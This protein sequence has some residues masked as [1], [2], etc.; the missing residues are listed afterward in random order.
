MTSPGYN[1][2]DRTFDN[3][4]NDPL[5][6]AKRSGGRRDLARLL[7]QQPQPFTGYEGEPYDP[8]R[9][10]QARDDSS[11]RERLGQTMSRIESALRQ[12]GLTEAERKELR[13]MAKSTFRGYLN[14]DDPISKFMG[15]LLHSAV[16]KPAQLVQLGILDVFDA[17]DKEIGLSDYG[18][19]LTGDYQ[20]LAEKFPDLL[21]E[22]GQPSFSTILSAAGWEPVGDSG[23]D[24]IGSG[25]M[26]KLARF[27]TT[28]AGEVATDPWTYLTLAGGAV[29]S[30]TRRAELLGAVKQAKTIAVEQVLVGEGLDDAALA[31]LRRDLGGEIVDHASTRA[32]ERKITELLPAAT[33]EAAEEL[34]EKS[35]HPLLRLIKEGEA[36]VD[37]L[38]AD[39]ASELATPTVRRSIVERAALQAED[40]FLERTVVPSA[41][42]AFHKIDP[43]FAELRKVTQPGA[44]GMFGTGLFP[45][46]VIGSYTTGGVRIGG[47]FG[48]PSVTIPGSVGINRRMQDWVA[49]RLFKQT[50]DPLDS[51]TGGAFAGLAQ[52]IVNITQSSTA[53][54]GAR[55]ASR[56]FRRISSGAVQNN[57][58]R[59]YGVGALRLQEFVAMPY[60]AQA[61]DLARRAA[62]THDLKQEASKAGG[63][64]EEVMKG[65]FRLI[66]EGGADLDSLTLAELRVA[67]KEFPE[68][69]ATEEVFAQAVQTARMYQTSFR[70]AYE[71]MKVIRP[72]LGDLGPSYVPTM[73]STAGSRLVARLADEGIDVI[74]DPDDPGAMILGLMSSAHQARTKFAEVGSSRHFQEREMLRGVVN[75]VPS[76]VDDVFLISAE[77]LGLGASL[78]QVRYG[79][80]GAANDAVM[81]ALRRVDELHPELGLRKIIDQ[82]GFTMF[83]DDIVKTAM[84]YLASMEEALLIHSAADFAE[85]YGMIASREMGS[86]FEEIIHQSLAEA[87]TWGLRPI[88]GEEPYHKLARL[89]IASER[90]SAKAEQ[91]AIVTIGNEVIS[92]SGFVATHPRWQ[93]LTREINQSVRLMEKHAK[94]HARQ[95]D[96]L[97]KDLIRQGYSPG[98]ADA[99]S[100]GAVADVLDQSRQLVDMADEVVTDIQQM[101]SVSLAD[102]RQKGIDYSITRKQIDQVREATRHARNKIR[103]RAEAVLEPFRQTKPLQSTVMTTDDLVNLEA[104]LRS[105]G[106]RQVTDRAAALRAQADTL[107]AE[108][109]L[110]G[111][112]LFDL[113]GNPNTAGREIN[114]LRHEANV[115]ERAHDP[116]YAMAHGAYEAA[117]AEATTHYAKKAS[118]QVLADIEAANLLDVVDDEIRWPNL[119]LGGRE[120]A[121]SEIAADLERLLGE[122]VDFDSEFFSHPAILEMVSRT[123][124]D[125]GISP[126]SQSVIHWRDAAQW[127]EARLRTRYFQGADWNDADWAKAARPAANPFAAIRRGEFDA[128]GRWIK[129]TD[130]TVW[131]HVTEQLHDMGLASRFEVRPHFNAASGE[132]TLRLVERDYLERKAADIPSLTELVRARRADEALDGPLADPDV[133]DVVDSKIA[134]ED[135]KAVYEG[136]FRA[137]TNNTAKAAREVAEFGEATERIGK[138]LDV[139]LHGTTPTARRTL[140]AALYDIDPNTGKWSLN[141]DGQLLRRKMT[142]EDFYRLHNNAEYLA[143]LGEMNARTPSVVRTMVKNAKTTQDFAAEMF[144]P[145]RVADRIARTKEELTKQL[146]DQQET[147]QLLDEF[148]GHLHTLRSFAPNEGTERARLAVGRTLLGSS[149]GGRPFVEGREAALSLVDRLARRKVMV[150][151]TDSLGR[152]RSVA[153]KVFTEQEANAAR[154]ALRGVVK[155]FTPQVGTGGRAIDFGTV[156]LGSGPLGGKVAIAPPGKDPRAL[157]DW[158][159]SYIDVSRNMFT[160]AGLKE[161]KEGTNQAVR[162]WR[163]AVT[164]SKVF[165]FN[166]R[167]LTGAM[168]Q[169]ML[170]GIAP[171]DPLYI[172]MFNLSTKYRVAMRRFGDDRLAAIATLPKKWQPLMRAATEQPGVLDGFAVNMLDHTLYGMAPALSRK[173]LKQMIN[174][175]S[176]GF[177][178]YRA[179]GKVMETVEDTVRLTLF[180]KHFSEEVPHS[181][182]NAAA[183]VRALHFDYSDLTSFERQIQKFSPFWVWWSRNL[184]LQLRVMVERPEMIMRYVK[185]QRSIQDNYGGDADPDYDLFG[186]SDYWGPYAAPTSFFLEKDSPYWARMFIDLDMPANDLLDFPLFGGGSNLNSWTTWL[187]NSL[188]PQVTVANEF[189]SPEDPFGAVAPFPLNKAMQIGHTLPL[190]LG[191]LADFITGYQGTYEATGQVKA[192]PKRVAIFEQ[193]FPWWRNIIEPWMIPEDPRRAQ[194]IGINPGD[195]GLD[196]RARGFLFEQAKGLGVRLQTP[197]DQA[198]ASYRTEQE[199]K[200][201]LDQIAQRNQYMSSDELRQQTRSRRT[202]LDEILRRRR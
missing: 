39:M 190:G 146:I 118:R 53:G 127:D 67:S 147:G 120:V 97:R 178:A 71:R 46:K 108:A 19:V 8:N 56:P 76:D 35:S 16:V 47:M 181:A 184:N 111:R 45:R 96:I 101:L 81:T 128:A 34:A 116:D 130:P 83:E 7:N 142:D 29:G 136:A 110:N 175:L 24:G 107:D 43:D 30:G 191:D 134:L 42:R 52:R 129:D 177:F 125:A 68:L 131:A 179:G 199:I 70:D 165:T 168:M 161:L 59:E 105:R 144:N 60:L 154:E 13:A 162:F 74:F 23:V 187:A 140:R 113:D 54:R 3:D 109:R 6:I 158:F 143:V 1:L 93:T 86:G 91:E 157:V 58:L 27:L 98:V 124:D 78:S 103:K 72:D 57:M 198:S 22:R 26:A 31:V 12:P 44:R 73:L 82:E 20:R 155:P 156:G 170:G 63:D 119:T 174:P 100:R 18:S 115:L 55:L 50:L 49:E 186:V 196:D 176:D 126:I 160:A 92:T 14:L 61:E 106:G 5:N 182:A 80:I 122:V 41:L 10:T 28:F 132:T 102:A 164:T 202:T 32:M 11:A 64:P 139:S 167:N 94:Q 4:P 25:G 151:K 152:V 40:Y 48:G 193:M 66:E 79:Q 121:G 150:E 135:A 51:M 153:E 117:V 114:R 2:I 166:A 38:I 87:Q 75:I 95:A 9:G 138:A 183:F 200:R 33:R 194:R 88:N 104:V 137:T 173:G 172:R 77:A 195:T 141:A 36:T 185:L 197:A 145:T 90:W 189:L 62:I 99:L 201:I 37:D 149:E 169:N 69:G 17:G 85:R 163:R 188:G 123:L 192:D 148:L 15:G 89:A 180:A 171:I 65:V 159:A 21:G 133:L 112:A 84:S